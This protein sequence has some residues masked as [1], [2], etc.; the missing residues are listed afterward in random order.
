[1]LETIHEFAAERLASSGEE[2]D[3]RRRH[4]EHV[5]DL[6]EEAEPHLMGE[7]QFR[8]LERLEQEHDN[9]RAA[10]DW[11]E[12]VDEAETAL[13]TAA[14]IWR[15]W[16]LRGHLAEGRA[17]LERIL[18]LPGA[19]A[20][21]RPRARALGALGGLAYWQGD[22]TAI[23]PLYEEAADIARE[24]GDRRLLSRAL[25]DLSFVP[26]VTGEG[27][28]HQEELL[29]EALAEAD[30]AD[31][32]L[33][34]QILTGLGYAQVFKGADPAD[35][36]R[37]TEEAL[38]I[39]REVGDRVLTAENLTGLAGL[40]LLSGDLDGAREPLREAVALLTDVDSPV[41]AGMA[42]FSLAVLARTEGD[43]VTMARLLGAWSRIKDEGGGAPPVFAVAQIIGDPESQAREAMG[44]EAYERA[45]AEG[46][47]MTTTQ[48]RTFAAELAERR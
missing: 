47:A 4:A 42:L 6:A 21:G 19:A 37:L 31:R 20:R 28:E 30:P 12:T 40:R 36:I 18:A 8:W 3:V 34:A 29:R 45:H 13:R 25:F 2:D 5:R 23:E 7:G 1:M 48:A 46:Y 24:L 33:R 39:H 10:L 26:M 32:P 43:H 11:A 38:T 22:Y 27:L 16:Q 9:V 35:V 15:F 14:A 17:R 41:M 44:D